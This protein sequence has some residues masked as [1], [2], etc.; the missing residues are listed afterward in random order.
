LIELEKEFGQTQVK[1][2]NLLDRPQWR[3]VE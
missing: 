2:Q 3:W 1:D